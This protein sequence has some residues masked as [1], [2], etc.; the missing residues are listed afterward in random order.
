MKNTYSTLGCK[1]KK[2]HVL[3]HFPGTSLQSTLEKP[4]NEIIQGGIE[5]VLS[6]KAKHLSWEILTQSEPAL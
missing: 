3:F 6:G 5:P 4:F 1:R 2:N